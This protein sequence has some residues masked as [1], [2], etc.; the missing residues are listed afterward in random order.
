MCYSSWFGLHSVTPWGN[1]CFCSYNRLTVLFCLAWKLYSFM[2]CFVCEYILF[3]NKVFTYMIKNH[4]IKVY[5]YCYCVEIDE[6]PQNKINT[7]TSYNLARHL[8]IIQLF[9]NC[10]GYFVLFKCFVVCICKAHKFK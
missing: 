4:K 2:K 8:C 6:K 1:N 3:T 10:S 5:T 7:G 9:S